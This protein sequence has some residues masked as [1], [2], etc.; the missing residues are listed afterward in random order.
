[1][2]L[3]ADLLSLVNLDIRER[4]APTRKMGVRP[5]LQ[6]TDLDK[7]HSNSSLQERIRANLARLESSFKN[8][9]RSGEAFPEHPLAGEFMREFIGGLGRPRGRI[10]FRHGQPLRK[11]DEKNAR[12][13]G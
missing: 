12:R 2:N 9:E 13:S 11:F 6:L 1:M 5:V 3:A 8:K 7:E 4:A 10:R